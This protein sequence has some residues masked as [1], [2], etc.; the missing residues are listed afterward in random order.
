MLRALEHEVLEEVGEARAPARL[1]ARADPV[2]DA[3]P[4]DGRRAVL[5]DDD[6]QAVREDE[7]LDRDL[8]RQAFRSCRAMTIRWISEVP[9]PIVQ[10]L[11]SR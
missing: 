11:T 9:S 5:R 1:E 10:S 3:E 4:E 2:E 8:Q 6:G 7:G